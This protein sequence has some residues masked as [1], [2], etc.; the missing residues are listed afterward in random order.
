MNMTVAWFNVNEEPGTCSVQEGATLMIPSVSSV[1]TSL[2][3]IGGGSAWDSAYEGNRCEGTCILRQAKTR[4]DLKKDESVNCA[5]TAETCALTT[6]MSANTCT[7]AA[8][9]VTADVYPL[10]NTALGVSA[11]VVASSLE[12]ACEGVLQGITSLQFSVDISSACMES[13]KSLRV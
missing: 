4:S 11:T 13:L 12:I 3:V 9:V 6:I 7:I 5:Q 1:L 8:P 10:S 2:S